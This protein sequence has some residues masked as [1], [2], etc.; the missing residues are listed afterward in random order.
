[1]EEYKPNSN[2]IKEQTKEEH[3]LSPIVSAPVKTKQRS[4]W[5]KFTDSFVSEDS[6]K[7]KD[8]ILMDVL[9]P[10]IKKT[11]S[12]IITN[13][14]DMLLFGGK[15]TA[16]NRNTMPGQRVSYRSY[17]D[18]GSANQQYQYRSQYNYDEII[19]DNRGDADA[20]INEMN[21]IIRR[22]G[23][24]RVAD[25]YDLVGITGSYTDNN[26]GWTDLRYADVIRQRDGYLLKF[27]RP[28]PID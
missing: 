25:L 1:M 26:Y 14:V 13:S 7:I 16:S 4:A 2:K 3:K 5:G 11:L 20:V 15:N 23:F 21:D 18:K 10:S 24:V 6:S 12:D 22:Y 28:M 27:P 9:L 17:Y 8:Y 19:L